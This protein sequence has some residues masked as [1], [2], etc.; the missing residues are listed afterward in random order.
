MNSTTGA[1]KFRIESTD[2]EVDCEQD[3]RDDA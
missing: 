3:V 1:H 2:N